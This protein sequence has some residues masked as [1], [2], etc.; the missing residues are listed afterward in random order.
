MGHRPSPP[1]FDFGMPH[2]TYG[3]QFH[4]YAPECRG[5]L[6]WLLSSRKPQEPRVRCLWASGAAQQCARL[7]PGLRTP[8][9]VVLFTEPAVSALGSWKCTVLGIQGTVGTSL[10][11]LSSAQM[12]RIFPLFP[13]KPFCLSASRVIKGDL[14]GIVQAKGIP[15][16]SISVA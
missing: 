12:L 16:V 15:P 1:K 4:S 10:P 7:I 5:R 13:L 8:A 11:A 6:R 3:L 2:P 14:S 9:S